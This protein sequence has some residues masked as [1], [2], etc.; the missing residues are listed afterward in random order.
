MWTRKTADPLGK[1]MFEKYSMH[2]LNRPRENVSVYDVFAVRNGEAFQSGGIESFLR[3]NFLK[4]EVLT[5]EALLDIDMTISDAV[6]GN[7]AL[8]F[9][10]GFLT[11]IGTGVVN[12]VSIALEKSHSR[13]LRFRFGGCTRDHVKDG[14]ELDLKLSEFPFVKETSAIK[15]GYQY[16]IASGVH[17]CNQLTFEVLDKNLV[18]IDLSADV[19]AL[20]A[21]KTGLTVNKDRQLTASSEKKLAY[22]VELNEIVYDE[23]RRRLNLQEARAYVHTKANGHL[24]L[25]KAVVGGPDDVMILQ[26]GTR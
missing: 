16:Y 2:A 26:I 19:A 6:S 14:F 23:K 1:L 8:N 10:Q 20:G 4:P 17:Y 9:L 7:V 5:N 15:E 22:G 12:A 3:S 18:K 21:G 11:L 13:A 24:E 25:P